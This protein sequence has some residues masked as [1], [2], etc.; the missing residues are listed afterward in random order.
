M[1]KKNLA[2]WI[3]RSTPQIPTFSDYCK[4]F[5]PF[6]VTAPPQVNRME[7]IDDP[8][9]S[10]VIESLR[11]ELENALQLVMHLRRELRKAREDS[12]DE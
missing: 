1:A 11:F 4:T 6:V 8:I 3:C 9:A 2:P 12:D 10:A 5:Q 7:S